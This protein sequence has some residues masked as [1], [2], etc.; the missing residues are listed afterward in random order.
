MVEFTQ[1]EA[2]A[3]NHF[4]SGLGWGDVDAVREIVSARR[5]IATAIKIERAA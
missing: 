1:A 4:L 3:V 5:R 2:E